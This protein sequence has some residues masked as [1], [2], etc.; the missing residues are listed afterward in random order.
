MITAEVKVSGALVEYL[1]V[2]NTKHI[3]GTTYEYQVEHYKPE[4]G[5]VVQFTIQHD[6]E[7]PAHD[8]MAACFVMAGDMR[9]PSDD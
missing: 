5:D 7:L 3:D 8:L 4:S 1:Y 9:R 2:R 6:Q